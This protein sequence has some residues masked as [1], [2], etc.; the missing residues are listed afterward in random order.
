MDVYLKFT[1]DQVYCLEKGM[2]LAAA[3]AA[4]T[5]SALTNEL[6]ALTS[7]AEYEVAETHAEAIV[8]ARERV[9]EALDN[10]EALDVEDWLD[11]ARR[12]IDDQ[13]QCAILEV[14]NARDTL[15]SIAL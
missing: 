8:E 9:I 1:A 6:N 3:V 13:L 11:S 12:G 7:L 14:E 15:M 2:R 10:L 4:L 5:E